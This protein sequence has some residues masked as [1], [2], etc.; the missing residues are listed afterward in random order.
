MADQ[1]TAEII[2]EAVERQ[3]GD[4]SDSFEVIVDDPRRADWRLKAA[5]HGRRGV[6]LACYRMN[7]RDVDVQLTYTVNTALSALDF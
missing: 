3:A 5:R 7:K 6:R 2:T 1:M 4:P